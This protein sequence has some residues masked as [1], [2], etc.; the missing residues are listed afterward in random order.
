[1]SVETTLTPEAIWTQL[2]LV[3]EHPAFKGSE[4]QRKFLHFIVGETLAGRASQIKGYTIAVSVYGRSERFDPQLDPIVRVEAGRLRRRLDQYYLTAGKNDPIRITIPKGGYVPTF[5]VIDQKGP[6][7]DASDR[8]N[9]A[10]VLR[11]KPSIAVMPLINLTGDPSQDYFVDGLTEEFTSELARYQD[12]CIIASQ[13][14]MHYKGKEAD[15]V[16]IGR[17]L[18]VRFL[19][20]GSVRRD[21][22]TIKVTVR[23]VDSVSGEQVWGENYTREL[24]TSNLIAIQEAIGRRVAGA[25]A[26]QYGLVSRRLSLESRKR[27]PEDLRAYDA[28]LRFYRYETQ[29]TPQAF[30]EALEALERAVEIE[31]NYALAWSMLGHLHADNYALGFCDIDAP[32]D[33]AL[34]FAQRGITLAPENQFASDALTLVHFHRGDKDLFFKYVDLTIALNPNSPYIIGVAGWHLMLYGEWERGLLFLRQGMQLN[35][36]YPSWFH[37]AT[38][39]EA[40]HRGDLNSALA[41]AIQFNFPTLYIDPMMRAAVLGQMGKEEKAR[42]ALD[43]LLKLEPDFSNRGRQLISR[44]V[45][46]DDLVDAIIEGLRRAG[47]GDLV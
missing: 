11:T 35:P 22:D 33:K 12:F 16:S 41:E 29:L 23:I 27:P 25:V 18:N 7:G 17:H 3:L 46:V 39:M 28:V 5:R 38:Y 44:Y 10:G 45:K 40:Y 47:L 6:A 20:Y 1:M 19:L 4:K 31:P 15:V 13:S 42:T 9:E 36:F 8:E 26:D 43:E 24:S 14:T 37:L 30:E 32:L 21:S 34:T 2:K